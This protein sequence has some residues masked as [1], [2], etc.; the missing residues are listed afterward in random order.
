M[1]VSYDLHR[2]LKLYES[3]T[4]RP[5]QFFLLTIGI[6]FQEF[7]SALNSIG[8]LQSLPQSLEL[9]VIFCHL[10]SVVV[11]RCTTLC[12]SLSLVVTRCITLMSFYKQSL[13]E[14]TCFFYKQQVYNQ[15]ALRWKI[16]KQLSRFNSLSLSNNKNCN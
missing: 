10:L 3:Q 6:S 14:C 16:A 4:K 11:T 13:I 8:P 9:I 7:V 2:C 1:F 15:L 12:H 5:P